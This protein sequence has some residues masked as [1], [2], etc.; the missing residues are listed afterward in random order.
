[1]SSPE[2]RIGVY[3]CQCGVNIGSVVNVEEVVN[4]AKTLPNV[5]VARN[6][7]YTCSSPG[8]EMI[9][10]DIADHQL[11]RVI[12]AACTPRLHET[13]FRRT[14]EKAG[15]NP[16]MLEIANIR[17][18]CVWVHASQP[19]KA[20]VKAKDLVRMAVARSRLLEPLQRREVE[21]VSRALVVGGGIA[22][23]RA[24]IDIAERGFEVYLV[25]KSPTLG[26]R[27][28]QL[29]RVFPTEDEAASL[30]K[31]L[32]ERISSNPA[33][34][35]LTNA[36]VES[37]DGFIGNF[38]TTISVKLRRVNDSCDGCAECETVCP[39]ELPNEYN[40]RL[41]VRKAIYLPSP[42]AYPPR[43]AID[44]KCNLCGKCISACTRNAINLTET[45]A[46]VEVKFAGII[47]ATG[48]D[49]YEPQN[50]E[51]GYGL[52]RKVITQPQFVRL[53]D[54]NGPTKGR[55]N[56]EGNP[57]KNVVFIACVGS[58]QHA[59]VYKTSQKDQKL[60][61]YCSRICC[62]TS[63]QNELALKKKYPECNVFHLY[64][65]IRTYGRGHEKIYEDIGNSS[66]YL[67]RYT[68]TDPPTVSTNGDQVIVT[69]RDSLSGGEQF[70]I[71][72]DLVVLGVGI[73]PRASTR[74]LQLKLKI[75]SGPD[76]FIQ[77]IH[78]K[79]RPVEVSTDGIFI[80]GTAQGPRDITESAISGSAAAAK[81]AITLSNGKVKLEPTIS[82]VDPTKCD[83]CA[84]CIE[85]CTF[86]AISIT[87][88]AEGSETKK[89]AVCE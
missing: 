89:R 76:G 55:L 66:V 32:C 46:K 40:Y 36:E 21:A 10:K 71:S 82:S 2:P 44:E 52:S 73:T 56:S 6:Y 48:F 57:P 33:I 75:P 15:L 28:A 8:Q 49:P 81:A 58:R 87:E 84:L 64:R 20:T 72:A 1:M 88:V 22:G 3:V 9:T 60:N 31:R 74:D 11:N 54:E 5:V 24:A 68:E 38:V 77:E 80:A 45:A 85:A 16:Y 43:Y 39:V 63:M 34:K 27:A 53:I 65:D 79:L 67:M 4:Y 51:F 61:E 86:K 14:I 50:G 69:V 26:G 35:V 37:V 17:E 42:S 62:S 83:G 25:E 12:V 18:H 19:Q 7:L 70:E 78:A 13:T 30:V 47:V 23:M 59:G 29:A 41:T